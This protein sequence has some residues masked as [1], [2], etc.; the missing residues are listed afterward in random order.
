MCP[1]LKTELTKI[2]A[3]AARPPSRQNPRRVPNGTRGFLNELLGGLQIT[4]RHRL[5]DARERDRR[6]AG[7][8]SR[9]IDHYCVLSASMDSGD[10]LW[11]RHTVLIEL[12]I[13]EPTLAHKRPLE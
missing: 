8:E 4:P 3:L 7:I 6:I 5:C 1:L 12:S 10:N 13:R 2:H 11:G 9:R